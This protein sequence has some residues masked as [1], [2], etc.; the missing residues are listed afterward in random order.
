MLSYNEAI[1]TIRSFTEKAKL[2]IHNRGSEYAERYYG[3]DEWGDRPKVKLQEYVGRVDIIGRSDQV[4]PWDIG[5][6]RI[7]LRHMDL[8]VSE[9]FMQCFKHDDLCDYT[10]AANMNKLAN[11]IKEFKD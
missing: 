3:T 10:N 4:K 9:S 2:Q 6:T 5:Y 1:A 8:Y 7:R 11:V